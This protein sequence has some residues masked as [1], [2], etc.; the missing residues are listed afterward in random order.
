MQITEPRSN[1]CLD[2][3]DKKGKQSNVF[4]IGINYPPTD[5]EKEEIN[6]INICSDLFPGNIL[7][8]KLEHGEICDCDFKNPYLEEVSLGNCE[9]TKAVI[10]HSKSTKDSRNST[11]IVLYRVTGK[12]TCRKYYLGKED[13]LLRVSG[14]AGHS[15]DTPLHF[16]SYD[17]LFEYLASLNTGGHTQN[18]FVQCKNEVNM[19]VRGE[20]IEIP[21]QIF[22][23][24]F[25]IFIHALKYDVEMAWDC[26]MCPKV[27]DTIKGMKEQDYNEDEV[28]ISDGI[29]MGTIENDVKG[30]TGQDIFEDEV[31]TTVVV[32]GIEA[33]ERTFVDKIKPRKILQTLCSSAMKCEDM[34]DAIK[35]IANCKATPALTK[36]TSLL[37]RLNSKNKCLPKEYFLLLSELG[38]CT[39]ISVLFPSHDTLEYKL[40][41]MYLAQEFDVFSDYKTTKVITNSFPLVTKI[42]K[43]ILKYE[44]LTFLPEDV[45]AI[46]EDIILLKNK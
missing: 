17:I 38:K 32:K 9:S 29:N 19:L 20:K 22:C 16:V 46:L 6:R 41:E 10:H 7:V 23:K 35:K 3:T 21:R 5:K 37:H 4:D 33:N 28:H 30:Y 15:R 25:E 27:L 24:A 2:P 18:A 1:N 12:C 42:C 31:D 8:P 43:R 44:N 36:I 39:P 34:K 45:T 40:L 26:I 13:K 11:L 14:I